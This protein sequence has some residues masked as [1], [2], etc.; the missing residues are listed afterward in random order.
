[1]FSTVFSPLQRNV[2]RFGE[3]CFQ[4]VFGNPRD[5]GFSETGKRWCADS[6]YAKLSFLGFMSSSPIRGRI[7]FKW[8]TCFPDFVLKKTPQHRGH[9]SEKKCPTDFECRGNTKCEEGV[10]IPEKVQW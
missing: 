1:M 2:F 10:C 7:L 8:L 3:K 6:S 4:S 9:F 5:F